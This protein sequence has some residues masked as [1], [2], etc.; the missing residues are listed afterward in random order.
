MKPT[1]DADQKMQEL[2]SGAIA[3]ISPELRIPLNTILLSVKLLE[4]YQ[5]EWSDE[6]KIQ[7]LQQIK[8]SSLAMRAILDSQDFAAN[9]QKFSEQISQRICTN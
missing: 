9:L 7:C 4:H 8:I 2:M 3:E 5:D 1:S 6:Q